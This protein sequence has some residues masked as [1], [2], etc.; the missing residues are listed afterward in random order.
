MGLINELLDL[1]FPQGI[2]LSPNT[3]EVLYSTKFPLGHKKDK[4][5][6]GSL[7]LAETG[8]PKSSR[9]LT[10]G[11]Y[12]DQK[13][14]WCPDGNSVAFV[15]DR[16]KQSESSAIYL[17]PT[18]AGGEAYPVTPA[19]NEKTI[20]AYQ[21]S[22]D[23]KFIAYVSADEKTPEKK[24][25]EEAKDDAIVWDTD[26]PFNRLRLIHVA[27]KQVT[28]LVSRDAHVTECFAWNHKGTKIAFTEART[29][30]IESAMWYGTKISILDIFSKQITEI[31]TF[32]RNLSQLVW[33]GDAL[34]FIGGAN[35]DTV[36]TAD[37]VYRVDL[38]APSPVYEKYAQGKDD[39]AAELRNAA[40]KCA[41]LVH[42]GMESRIQMPKDE[43]LFAVK[44]DIE[45]W[46]V[47][48]SPESNKTIAAFS[49]DDTASPPEVF[50]LTAAGGEPVQVS[51]HGES[52]AEKKLGYATF[53]QCKSSDGKVDLDAVYLIPSVFAG[54]DGRP[55]K[56]LPT[57]VHSHGGPYGRNT[58]SFN[59]TY[60][61]WSGPLLSA[62]YGILLPNYRGGSGRG[63]EFAGAVRAACGTVDYDDV[64]TTTQHAIEKGFADK[65]R[66]IHAGWSQGGFMSFLCT[67]RNGLHGHG[68]K[69][70]ATI[71]GA[72]VS[73]GDTMSLTSDLGAFQDDLAGQPPWQ[74]DKQD[75]SGR[76]GSAIWEFNDAVNKGDVIP[77]VLI[78]HGEKDERVPLEQA[79]GFRRAMMSANLPFEMVVYPREPHLFAERQHLIDMANRVVKFVD[80]HIGGK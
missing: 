37:M 32:P 30:D 4:H 53:F 62:G 12:N 5:V 45:T 8:K 11:L 15:S 6:C 60:K 71:P 2:R 13:P 19:D 10:S 24:A 20:E 77:P 7:W 35:T 70:K 44:K 54:K 43:T 55:T 49:Q 40:G 80:T 50:T 9:Q 68:W 48:S 33:A 61:L 3:Q 38:K 63:D 79:V 56:P 58:D 29:P 76:T 14:E 72:G 36:I 26:W 27:T 22:P 31:C 66:L 47:S 34:Y 52:I 74:S 18:K 65:D 69:F 46:D 59:P 51:N 28:T 73:D 42:H 75:T 67:V 25:K 41:V 57:V 16:A 78:L 1:Q 17:L 64:I 21:F 23:G 39:C